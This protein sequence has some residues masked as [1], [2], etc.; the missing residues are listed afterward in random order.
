MSIFLN[1]V[2]N[3][4]LGNKERSAL[5]RLRDCFGKLGKQ[6]GW[7]RDREKGEKGLKVPTESI[8]WG[9]GT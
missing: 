9:R 1:V 3:I 5:S 8:W 2:Y 6:K 4:I 7:K